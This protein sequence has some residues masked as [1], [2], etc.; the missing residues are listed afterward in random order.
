MKLGWEKSCVS[1]SGPQGW[2]APGARSHSKRGEP[3]GSEQGW[4]RQRAAAGRAGW[5]G[6]SDAGQMLSRRQ[7]PGLDLGTVSPILRG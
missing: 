3:E 5:K 7:L 1:D 6:Q 2:S 4:E